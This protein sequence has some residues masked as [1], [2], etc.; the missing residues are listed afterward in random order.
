M[1]DLVVLLAN[2]FCTVPVVFK[3]ANIMVD[4]NYDAYR[5]NEISPH[6]Q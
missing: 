5:R 4:A 3:A 6:P 1:R 2:P